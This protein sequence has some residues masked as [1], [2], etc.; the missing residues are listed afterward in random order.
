MDQEKQGPGSFFSIL[1]SNIKIPQNDISL[2]I[3]KGHFLLGFGVSKMK[4]GRLGALI[5]TQ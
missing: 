5:L 2:S 4:R 3:T 1:C